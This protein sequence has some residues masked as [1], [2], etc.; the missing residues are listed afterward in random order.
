MTAMTDLTPIRSSSNF[1][2]ERI[3]F[4]ISSC[5]EHGLKPQSLVLFVL[6]PSHAAAW[7]ETSIISVIRVIRGSPSPCW[8]AKS[9]D[10]SFVSNDII[11]HVLDLPDPGFHGG[12]PAIA[13]TG[14]VFRL[15]ICEDH[16]TLR[17]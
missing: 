10:C 8:S 13:L 6:L 16:Y 14:I 17:A 7:L 15:A 2:P 3:P 9:Q 1:S 5:R 12:R 4:V 11:A